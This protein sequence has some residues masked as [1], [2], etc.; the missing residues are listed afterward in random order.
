MSHD[1]LQKLQETLNRTSTRLE[2]QRKEQAST[3]VALSTF[4]FKNFT[5]SG[6][7]SNIVAA[8]LTF[9]DQGI[10]SLASFLLMVLLA[11]ELPAADF[12]AFVLVYM[13]IYLANNVQTSLV[14]RPLNLIGANLGEPAFREYASRLFSLQI[15]ITALFALAGFA[16]AF[17]ARFMSEPTALLFAVTTLALI[18]WQLQEFARQIQFT[19]RR[20]GA[21]LA[22][23]VLGYGGQ[24][25][26]LGVLLTAG[27][28]TA[29]S[30]MLVLAGSLALSAAFGLR[31]IGV[32]PRGMPYPILRMHWR[33]GRWI[34]GDN[35]GQWLSTMLF[36]FLTAAF[37]GT[38][39]T[40]VYRL[41]MNVVA[42][43]HV[44]FNAAPSFAAPRA[45][46]A[47]HEGGVKKLFGFL[48]PTV[49]LIGLPVS[50]YLLGVSVFG[51]EVLRLM[52]G[53]Q[54]AHHADL[55]W[56]FAAAYIFQYLIDAEAIALLAL[57]NPRSIFLGRLTSIVLTLTVGVGLTA[58]YGVT[59]AV[60]GLIVTNGGFFLVLASIL[61]RLR[62]KDERRSESISLVAARGEL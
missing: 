54:Y 17:S 49:I 16:A 33:M 38:A 57:G 52:Y 50:V 20:A 27:S 13:A 4:P 6:R 2:D 58:A 41:V 10:V 43:L 8:G 5:T 47:Y 29:V 31:R 32:R 51:S 42:P 12:G 36:P 26:L 34:M 62:K 44:I 46:R 61:S 24:V 56:L 21:V 59:G 15:L 55:I 53:S 40:A 11:R 3:V 22:V 19:R 9:A 45:S 23:D 39:A 35:L 60:A 48:V 7:A 28:L 30:A 14:S 37:A 18:G 1:G 25:V